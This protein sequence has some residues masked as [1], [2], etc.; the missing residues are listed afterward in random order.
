[1]A[2]H[3]SRDDFT[4]YATRQVEPAFIDRLSSMVEHCGCGAPLRE[5][6]I[7]YL[8][9][10]KNYLRVER[11]GASGVDEDIYRGQRGVVAVAM[12]KIAADKLYSS[13][14]IVALATREAMQNSVD[15]VRAAYRSRG[16]YRLP[17]GEGY[18][19]VTWGDVRRDADGEYKGTLVFED[20][21]IGMD[22]KTAIDKLLKLG[23]TEKPTAVG[24]NGEVI[25]VPIEPGAPASVGGFGMAKAIIF[26]TSST[27]RFT[28]H[29]RDQLI[30]GEPGSLDFTV[31]TVE[32]RQGTKIT[33]YDV[34]ASSVWNSMFEAHFDVPARI[35]NVLAY[36]DTP[37][38]KLIFGW[39]GESSGDVVTPFFSGRRGSTLDFP[40]PLNWGEGNEVRVR[41]YRRASGSGSGNLYV[42]LGGL[43]QFAT[44]PEGGAVLPSDILFDIETKNT[45]AQR[46]YPLNA[47]REEW[48]GASAAGNTF[49]RIRS[50]LSKEAES[51][52]KRSEWTT[53]LP[54]STDE[55][56]R[57]GAE[58]FANQFRA[59]AED[60]EFQATLSELAGAVAD[61]YETQK[62]QRS[63]TATEVE[64]AAPGG[65]ENPYDNFRQWSQVIPTETEAQT[66]EGRKRLGEVTLDVVQHVANNGEVD[67][68]VVDILGKLQNGDPVTPDEARRVIESVERTRERGGLSAI[69][70][71]SVQDQTTLSIILDRLNK[72]LAA[73]SAAH[74]EAT[75]EA[76]EVA[77]KRAQ[78]INPFGSAGV[79]K[80]SNTHY[81][82]R[83]AAAFLRNA[84][85]YIPYLVAWDMT[86]RLVA[87]EGNFGV[88]KETGQTLKVTIPFRPGFVLD[89]T[90][91]GL[92]TSDGEPGSRSFKNFVLFN[93][94]KFD[95]VVKAYKDKPWAIAGYLHGVASH[96]IAH[97]PLMGQGHNES[98]AVQ[99]EDLGF[100]TA[101]LLPAIEQLVTRLL[102]LRPVV[103]PAY[104]GIL[105]A[106]TK[107]AKD[108]ARESARQK[109]AERTAQH[110]IQIASLRQEIAAEANL[111]AAA[112]DEL[113]RF[114]AI[115]GSMRG[116]VEDVIWRLNQLAEYDEFRRWLQGPGAS[117]LP[118]HVSVTQL[119]DVLDKN[120]SIAV[121]VLLGIRAAS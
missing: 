22:R 1:M 69:P 81:D 113:E 74:P 82:K 93:P 7:E 89:D 83:S 86:L 46:Q 103:S 67:T 51:A 59:M 3:I 17:R 49:R 63:R 26:A 58:D 92:T 12:W 32:R 98:W 106:A 9:E 76:V 78:A 53:L 119:L 104:T 8:R 54:D 121:D 70:E 55:K 68:W 4:Q 85:K 66:P 88:Q 109:I 111:H 97:L 61:Y 56:E 24:P 108:A 77:K 14:D 107:A 33:L 29:T 21:G 10:S 71:V 95:E 37:D 94:D 79:V 105:A 43:F 30:E 112:R 23:A 35:K 19:A 15:A 28:V 31:R 5:K 36:S 27:E 72:V 62:P 99:R 96:E 60:P 101:H 115:F 45:P 75:P 2:K 41:G 116:R 73:S 16:P 80:I 6:A 40:F 90:V 102:K 18:F 25:E 118:G 87:G 91:R 64:S 39:S 84:K 11:A 110:A 114:K 50:N 65:P 44:G 52:T 120:P 38:V 42:R 47:S 13:G 20:N 57:E 48:N 34:D 117:F 100:S